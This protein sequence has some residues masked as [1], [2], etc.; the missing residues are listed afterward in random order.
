VDL[1]SE[2]LDLFD[3]VETFRLVAAAEGGLELLLQGK[4]LGL[5]AAGLHF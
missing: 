2:L 4:E 1:C 5:A 3:Q